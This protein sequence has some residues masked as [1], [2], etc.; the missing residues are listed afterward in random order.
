MSRQSVPSR[1][2]QGPSRKGIRFAGS[3]AVVAV[4]VLLV[5]LIAGL[6]LDQR[7]AASETNPFNLGAKVTGTFYAYVEAGETLDVSFGRFSNSLL[8]FRSR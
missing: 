6:T 3:G 2:G 5:A 4:A 8:I 7:H 1:S